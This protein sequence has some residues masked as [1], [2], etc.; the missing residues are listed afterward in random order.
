MPVSRR[1]PRSTSIL[2][3]FTRFT[4]HAAGRYDGARLSDALLNRKP[5]VAQRLKSLLGP[6]LRGMGSIHL[7]LLL[8]A[9][10]AAYLGIV[11]V[12]A[13]QSPG[14]LAAV[15]R[16]PADEAYG[17]P[18]LI[19]LLAALVVNMLIASLT[20]IPLDLPHAG[21]WMSHL[22][23][24]TL[25]AGAMLYAAFAVKGYCAFERDETNWPAVTDFYEDGTHAIYVYERPTEAPKVVKLP[26]R[27]DGRDEQPL[28]IPVP[29]G[30]AGPQ[31]RVT[32]YLRNFVV[33]TPAGQAVSPSAVRLEAGEG[34]RRDVTHLPLIWAPARDYAEWVRLPGGRWIGFCYS[35][36]TR[37]LGGKVDLLGAEYQTQP[38]SHVPKDYRCDL[39]VTR[40]GRE[41]KET[42]SLNNPVKLGPYQLSQDRWE[43]ATGGQPSVIFLGVRSR[44]G[45]PAIWA[46]CSMIVAG[47]L[48]AFYVKPLLLRR[49][50]TAE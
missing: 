12:W 20:R 38:G 7:G 23:V 22:G 15:L 16:R 41:R 14:S 18:V 30:D 31:I 47:L 50:R 21:A 5:L 17:H 2:K 1:A 32:A 26:I 44:P 43:P 25:A 28:N 3:T 27:D 9:L 4:P 42:L 40:E 35:R 33:L 46:G 36:L 48:W 19:A 8:L 34:D 49:R 13:S 24:V 11:S 39:R 45:L 37:P 29:C 10:V 6:L